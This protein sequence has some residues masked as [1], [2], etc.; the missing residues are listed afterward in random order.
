M[1]FAFLLLF[2][3]SF[4]IFAQTNAPIDVN[5]I[6]IARDQWGVPHIF[7]E[8][9]IEAAYGLAWAHAEDN[10]EQIQEPLLAARSLL[11]A[12]LGKDGALFDAVAFLINS[13][14]I[15]DEKYERTF[16]PKFKKI[17]AAYAA[18]LNQYAALHP[19]EI[20]HK[21]LFPIH[22]KD[23]VTAYNLSTALITDIQADLG[24]LFQSN[25][26]PITRM[27][28]K[29][30]SAGSN[31]IA[32]APH[33]TKEGKTFLLSNSHQP[34]RSYLSWY[35]VH[36]HTEE[37]W[38]FTG[39]TFCGGVTPFVGTNEHLGWTHCVNYNDYCDV[40]ELTMHPNKKLHYK[41]DNQWLELE[42]RVWKTK[43]KIGFLKVGIK[44][45]FYW[46]KH[47]P[48]IKNKTGFY[49]LRFPANMVIGAPEQWYHMNKAQS[50]DE[51]KAALAL[52]EQPNLST[53]YADKKG[54]IFFIDNGLFPYRDPNYE[55]DYLLPGDTSATIWAPNFMPMDSLLQVENPPAGYVFHMNGSG[56]NST[57]DADN[58]N[59]NDYNPTMGYV[60]GAIPRHLRFKE[61][62]KPY[63][64]LSY[65]DFKTIK[66]DQNRS[67]PLYTRTIE[68]WDLLR[69]LSP[70]TYPDLAD[71]IA[72]FS[73]WD[74]GGDIH[75]KQAAIFSL[76]NDYIIRYM[77]RKG[78]ADRNG[79]LPESAFVEALRFAKK[80]LLKHF[81]TLEIELGELQKHVRGDKVLPIGG[82]G[83]SIAAM[84][85]IPWKKG[86]VQ[87]NL[88][89]S[90]ILFA[91]YNKSGVEKIETINCYG[92][93]NR[94]DSPH[95]NDQVDLY[96]QQKTK[97]M[98]LDKTQILKTA[99]RTYHPK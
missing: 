70:E 5:N 37:G 77:G 13:K 6:T 28:E 61:L 9:D 22:P 25:L 89:D 49:A 33:K 32:L 69:Q 36:I 65:E 38:N 27:D 47:G 99:K 81:K 16:S 43:V 39:A 87:S 55:W 83:E 62:M 41:L 97:V 20:R 50:L 96:I 2:L 8:T 92:A 30:L 26:A 21:K 17:L 34:L 3:S 46:S 93:S 12:V 1:I 31:G 60:S 63:K 44:K 58:P 90:F 85:T 15:V 54:N 75:N 52:Q 80:H 82:L 64:K 35:E 7:S 10:F 14:A 40:Y 73:K 72:V 48:V 68:N 29:I 57:A 91:T 23:I 79:S 88:G 71:I 53:I 95:Y 45:K 66:Y 67:L 19:K 76:A 24:R 74:G 98:S 86:R 78:I 11:G 42:E 4:S 59:P 84:Y 51:F 94:P 18:G 56:F